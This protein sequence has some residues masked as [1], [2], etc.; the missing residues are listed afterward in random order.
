LAALPLFGSKEL[1]AE[2]R[3]DLAQAEREFDGLPT[4][5]PY[6]LLKAADLAQHPTLELPYLE[7][8]EAK[9]GETDFTRALSA[10]EKRLAPLIPEPAKEPEPLEPGPTTPEIEEQDC[11]SH[12]LLLARTRGGKTNA[13][14]WRIRQLL[15][16]IAEGRASLILMEPKGPLIDDVLHLRA[17]WKLR[18]RVVIIDPR[19]IRVSVNIFDRGNGSDQAIN[20]AVERISRIFGTI[21]ADL[22]PMQRTPLTFAI[23]AM[24][25]V[26]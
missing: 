1:R 2:I 26:Q 10:F 23:R 4:P 16:Q 20:E 17:T 12:C 18:D 3:E 14:R 5:H 11:Y 6:W 25:A 9:K 15:P 13:I 7:Y 22:T 21:T 24:F 8:A 19:D